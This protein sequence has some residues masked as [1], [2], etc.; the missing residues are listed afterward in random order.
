VVHGRRL[1]DVLGSEL[2]A[3]HVFDDAGIEPAAY[4]DLGSGA[5]VPGLVLAICWPG[6]RG[7]LLDSSRRRCALLVEAVAALGLE[8]QVSVQCGRA[9]TLAR[10]EGLRAGFHLVVARGFGS[11]AVTAECAVGFLRSGGLLAVTEPPGGDAVGSTRWPVDPLA[12]LGLGPARILRADAMGVAVMTAVAEPAD[13][14]PRA[15]GRPAKSP[16][17]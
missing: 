17:W 3:A 1:A 7:T 12:A 4:L 11:P 8:G 6:A 15:D 5:G 14:W 13:R 2:R 9:E 10:T 16:L